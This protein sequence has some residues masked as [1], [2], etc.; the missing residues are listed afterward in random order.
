MNTTRTSK[1]SME[2]LNEQ[3]MQDAEML[4]NQKMEKY[5]SE[6]ECANESDGI[7]SPS[8]KDPIVEHQK[9]S[10]HKH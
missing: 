7:S 10:P 1:T 4:E 5:W 2:D 9:Y 8:K 3:L 6:L